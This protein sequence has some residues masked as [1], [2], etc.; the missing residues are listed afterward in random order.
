M[1]TA[2]VVTFTSLYGAGKHEPLASL[3]KVDD[4][5]ILLD[6]GWNEAFNEELLAPLKAYDLLWACRVLRCHARV[7]FCSIA[8]DI[9]IVLLSHGDMAHCGALPYA[10]SK[11]LLLSLL[12]HALAA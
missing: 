8:P 6:C 4:V 5:N 7:L 11:V 1:A 10:V 9:D 12:S 2:V 3:L